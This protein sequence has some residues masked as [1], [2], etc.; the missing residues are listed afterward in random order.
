MLGK[1]YYLNGDNF[2]KNIRRSSALTIHISTAAGEWAQ[3]VKAALSKPVD[4]V[5]AI[6]NCFEKTSSLSSHYLAQQNMFDEQ[7]LV[8][9]DC[10]KM[11]TFLPLCANDEPNLCV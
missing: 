8:I 11:A 10:T 5:Q 7:V 2:G 9:N 6:S 1:L 3:I 4:F